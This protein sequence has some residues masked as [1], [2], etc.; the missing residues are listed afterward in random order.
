VHP[1]HEA[2]KQLVEEHSIKP[3]DIVEVVVS[4]M[5]TSRLADYNPSGAVDAMFSL[6]YTIATTILKEK[7]LPDMYSEEKIK[8][9][10][11]Q[12]L[13]KKIQCKPD[14]EADQLWYDNQWLVFTIEMTLKGGKQIKQR[15]EWPKEKPPFGRK[16]VEQKFRDLASLVVSSDRVEQIVQTVENL[17]SLPDIAELTALLHD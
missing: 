3:D 1:V 8:S 2:V 4:G 12:G 15:V 5:Q 9:P 17:D 6:P 7:L 10:E 11:V 14:P 13:L 16:E